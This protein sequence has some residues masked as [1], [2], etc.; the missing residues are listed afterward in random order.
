MLKVKWSEEVRAPKVDMR[1]RA[2]GGRYEID[3]Y[4]DTWGRKKPRWCYGVRFRASSIS[5]VYVDCGGHTAKQ[6]DVESMLRATLKR[7]RAMVKA[8]DRSMG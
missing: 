4:V 3:A 7:V 2:K 5:K 8:F 1:V 6:A